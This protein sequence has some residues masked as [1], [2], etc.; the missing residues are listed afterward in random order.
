M[1]EDQAS[2]LQATPIS[3]TIQSVDWIIPVVQSIHIVT[4]GVVFVSISIVAL[5]VLGKI[6]V[7]QPFGA[8]MARFSPWIWSGLVVMAVTG[9]TLVVGEPVRQFTSLSFWMKLG[10]IVVGS[11]SAALFHR[12]LRN[13]LAGADSEPMFSPAVRAGAAMT[14][15]LWRWSSEPFSSWT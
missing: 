4:I 9:V 5:R 11:G 14:I 1:F 3:T 15:L 13:A 2:R 12:S 10:L 7:D 6:C 8:V